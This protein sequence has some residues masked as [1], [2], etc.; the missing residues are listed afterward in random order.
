ME[1]Q[2][3]FFVMINE[4][5]IQLEDDE[6]VKFYINTYQLQLKE[7]SSGQ[8]VNGL[9]L[10]NGDFRVRSANKKIYKPVDIPKSELLKKQNYILYI[11]LK[12]L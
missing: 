1:N 12:T 7:T 3:Q 8:K 4:I 5:K 11:D 10:E 9:L 2:F 6:Y